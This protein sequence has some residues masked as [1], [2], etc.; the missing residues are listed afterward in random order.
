VAQAELG[1][2]NLSVYFFPG[3]FCTEK[4][5]EKENMNTDHKFA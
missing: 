4:E 1:E 3:Q 2:D 5:K